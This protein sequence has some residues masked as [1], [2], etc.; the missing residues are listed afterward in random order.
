M[1][2]WRYAALLLG[3]WRNAK[4][5]PNLSIRE[6]DYHIDSEVEGLQGLQAFFDTEKAALGDKL[7][8][9]ALVRYESDNDWRVVKEI[10]S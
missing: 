8:T 3:V 4:H 10:R 1:V 9:V 6:Y 2:K 5:Q 7:V